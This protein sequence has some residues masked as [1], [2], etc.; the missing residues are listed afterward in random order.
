[1][2]AE[3]WSGR[4]LAAITDAWSTS[5]PSTIQQTSSAST[6]MWSRGADPPSRWRAHT[7]KSTRHGSQRLA[8]DI[9]NSVAE[10]GQKEATD[11]GGARVRLADPLPDIAGVCLLVGESGLGKTLF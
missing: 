11:R 8:F 1:M 4:R 10:A 6:K 5:R 3:S 7:D 9:Q 2:K